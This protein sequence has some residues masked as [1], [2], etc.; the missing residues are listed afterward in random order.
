MPCYRHYCRAVGR[1]RGDHANPKAPK[2]L[3]PYTEVVSMSG[4]GTPA[5]VASIYEDDWIVLYDAEA[6]E[7]KLV[8]SVSKYGT[9][10]DQR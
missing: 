2:E 6:G 7:L 8:H 3:E 1:D 9:N 4:S 10:R 5:R